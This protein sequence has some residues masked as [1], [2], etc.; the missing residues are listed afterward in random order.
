M[1][2]ESL[3]EME[4]SERMWK[5]I[6]MKSRNGVCSERGRRARPWKGSSDKNTILRR[7]QPDAWKRLMER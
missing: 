7:A 2:N 4:I 6:E 1:Q 3:R 5:V